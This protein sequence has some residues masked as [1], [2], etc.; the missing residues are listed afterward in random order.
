MSD[1]DKWAPDS[2]Q[3]QVVFAAMAAGAAGITSLAVY[4]PLALAN[5]NGTLTDHG[6][7]RAGWTILYLA[8]LF[9]VSWLI[10]VSVHQTT[11]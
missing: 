1:T 4:G 8:L 6:L 9:L 10:M 11:K 2:T 3:R 5:K 7:K